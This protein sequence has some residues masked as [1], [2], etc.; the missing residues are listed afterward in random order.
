MING[1]PVYHFYRYVIQPSSMFAI[2][3]R[4][5]RKRAAPKPR[6]WGSNLRETESDI[7][8]S[9]IDGKYNLPERQDRSFSMSAVDSSRPARFRIG[10]VENA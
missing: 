5:N 10:V 9:D 3:T 2:P 4:F 1:S 7:D 6:S 8:P